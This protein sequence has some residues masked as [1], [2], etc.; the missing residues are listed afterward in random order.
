MRRQTLAEPGPRALQC[1][2]YGRDADVE[3][4][5]SVLRG[6]I[7]HVAQNQGSP[8]LR[9]EELDYRQKSDLDGLA[10]QRYGLWR[11]LRRGGWVEYRVRNR[12]QPD[13]IIRLPGPA[14]IRSGPGREHRPPL[15]AGN[16]IEAG[17]RGHAV[18]PRAQGRTF[19]QAVAIPP[20]AK[21]SFLH[22]VLG[23]MQGAEHPVTVDQQLV[24]MT[25]NGASEL[26][27]CLPP[28]Q[29][30]RYDQRRFLTVIPE[31]GQKLIARG[32]RSCSR[33][34]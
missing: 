4:V 7:Q 24:T 27:H 26:V 13:D 32:I 21:Q 20:G 17:V 15:I 1:A 18:E 31:Q 10:L 12:P 22:R 30:R 16:R 28:S 29:L 25:L 9:C 23:V 3:Q 11:L 33:N 5:G 8:L 6:P 34:V 2:V 14:I 19:L